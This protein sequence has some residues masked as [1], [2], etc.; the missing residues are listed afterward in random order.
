[1]INYYV[2]APFDDNYVELTNSTEEVTY[3]NASR[4]VFPGVDQ[5]FLAA[6]APK[7]I[8][9]SQFWQ[10]VLQE[11]VSFLCSANILQVNLPGD[12]HRDDHQ[13]GGV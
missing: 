7:E 9:Y 13:A 5:K 4:I 2:L 12:S 1:M 11:N 10:M 3:V 6:S 8:S